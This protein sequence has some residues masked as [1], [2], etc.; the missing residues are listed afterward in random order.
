MFLR[1]C[2]RPPRIVKSYYCHCI[3][4]WGWSIQRNWK[5]NKPFGQMFIVSIN[6][7]RWIFFLFCVLCVGH[8]WLGKSDRAFPLFWGKITTSLIQLYEFVR[9][10]F[11]WLLYLHRYMGKVP[12]AKGTTF[13]SSM[14]VP[15]WQIIF[16]EYD[17]PWRW[18]K[19][20]NRRNIIIFVCS[21]SSTVVSKTTNDLPR[22]GG[23]NL[24]KEFEVI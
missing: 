17:S 22:V 24:L 6:D 1:Y 12:I 7:P 18:N 9:S 3:Q 21:N 10:A 5:D 15:E 23:Y 20:S 8:L 16:N 19:L 14:I 11:L 13:I 4:L 2:F